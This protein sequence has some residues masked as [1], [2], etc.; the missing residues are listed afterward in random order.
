MGRKD[1]GAEIYRQIN[2]GTVEIS[3]VISLFVNHRDELVNWGIV[4]D[5]HWE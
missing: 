3:I 5:E 1:V 2:S 4:I